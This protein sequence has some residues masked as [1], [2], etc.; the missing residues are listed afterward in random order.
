MLLKRII[1][2]AL[3]PILHKHWCLLVSHKNLVNRKRRTIPNSWRNVIQD[4][5]LNRRYQRIPKVELIQFFYLRTTLIFQAPIIWQSYVLVL[6]D[7]VFG[8]GFYWRLTHLSKVLFDY[9]SVGMYL[10]D[11]VILHSFLLSVMCELTTQPFIPWLH[12]KWQ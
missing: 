3:G 7:K 12:I 4:M 2:E 9:S 10:R 6:K 8:Y 5:P 1:I 11:K